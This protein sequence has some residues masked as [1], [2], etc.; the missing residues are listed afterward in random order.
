M[1]L[2]V[3]GMLVDLPVTIMEVTG[4]VSAMQLEVSAAHIY[5]YIYIIYYNIRLRHMKNE[6]MRQL[7]ASSRNSEA[8][9][10]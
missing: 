7:H 4:S 9:D 2:S 3:T 5:I 10:V 6:G 8:I 1:L